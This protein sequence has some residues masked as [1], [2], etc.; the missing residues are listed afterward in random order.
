MAYD[1]GPHYPIS[2]LLKRILAFL[3]QIREKVKLK[4]KRG[5]VKNARKTKFPEGLLFSLQHVH[6]S[7]RK[8]IPIRP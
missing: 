3:A 6:L 2:H 7:E 8:A 5:R 1:R 4:I